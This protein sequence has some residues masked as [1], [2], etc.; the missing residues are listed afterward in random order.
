LSSKP[1]REQVENFL[2]RLSTKTQ[3]KNWAELS[4]QPPDA[5]S[6]LLAARFSYDVNQGGFAQLLFNMGGELLSEIEEMLIAANASAARSYYLRALD[7]CL[8]NKTEYF[9]FLNSNYLD[10]NDVKLELQLLSISYHQDCIPFVTESSEFLI[11]AL[12]ENA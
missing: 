2:L 10:P 6:Y 4:A 8:Q 5:R 3:F 7:I 12:R 9:R 11:K 1:T